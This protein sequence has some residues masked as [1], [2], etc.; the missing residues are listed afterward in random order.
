[1]VFWR[2]LAE[3]DCL[4]T[5]WPSLLLRTWCPIAAA[6]SFR[7]IKQAF[8]GFHH[9]LRTSSSAGTQK[10]QTVKTPS[11]KDQAP[12]R[13]P[14][15]SS[16]GASVYSCGALFK[17]PVK[18]TPWRGWGLEGAQWWRALGFSS[19]EHRFGSQHAHQA[20]HSCLELQLLKSD[21]PTLMSTY[22]RANN[23]PIHN[24]RNNECK[25]INILHIFHYL[26]NWWISIK[27]LHWFLVL[28]KSTLTLWSP[29]F[30]Y[31]HSNL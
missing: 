21:W 18:H 4:L 1:M 15:V 23:P 3:E 26:T 28:A 31:P 8:A 9:W 6:E 2:A 20:A 10:I 19:W 11:L 22:S 25:Y 24:F 16:L 12:S 29:Q 17:P 5:A 13:F 14:A 27:F 30:L 7:D